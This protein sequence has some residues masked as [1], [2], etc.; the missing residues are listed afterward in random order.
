MKFGDGPKPPSG[1]NYTMYSFDNITFTPYPNSPVPVST[2][3]TYNLYYYSVDNAGNVEKTKGPFAFK[4]DKTAPVFTNFSATPENAM[5][6]KWLLHA[7]FSADLSGVVRV[8]FY[9]NDQAAGNATSAPWEVHFNG[10]KGTAQAIAYDAAGNSRMSDQIK[11]L[12]FG[13]QLIMKGML[14]IQQ[15]VLQ[16]Q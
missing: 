4:L 14:S 9:V 7:E 13:S 12:G 1:V 15:Q 8:E 6:S 3:G 16:Q 2:D 11:S 10:K 5:K